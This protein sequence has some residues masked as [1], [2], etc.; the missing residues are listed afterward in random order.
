MVAT[1]IDLEYRQAIPVHALQTP[2][3]LP[4]GESRVDH[5]AGQM[6]DVLGT[7]Y[8]EVRAQIVCVVGDAY[9]TNLR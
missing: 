5:Y 9:Y 4:E 7:L 1:L 3:V 6:Q 2:A 8:P